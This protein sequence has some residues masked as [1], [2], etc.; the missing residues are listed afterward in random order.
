MNVVKVKC[1]KFSETPFLMKIQIER[2]RHRS[3]TVTMVTEEA[4]CLAWITLKLDIT[5]VTGI[6]E[7][8]WLPCESACLPY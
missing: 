5:M 1:Q 4:A 8:R 6:G 3:C 7:V 2:T